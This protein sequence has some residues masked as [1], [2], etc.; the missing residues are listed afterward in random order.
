MNI[1]RCFTIAGKVAVVTGGSAGIG[2]MIAEGLVRAGA[3]VFI[4]GRKQE[5]LGE[6]VQRLSEFGE[7][8]PIQADLG[9]AEGIQAVKLALEARV[10]ELNILINNAGTIWIAPFEDFPRLGFEKLFALNVTALFDLTRTL[11]PLLQRGA[12]QDDPARVVNVT[13]VAGMHIG[14]QF[15]GELD[16]FSYGASKAAANMLTRKLAR[17]LL[18]DNIL[19]N[20]VA[21]GTFPT[22]MN[23]P[24]R[25]DSE[26]QAAALRDI[27][28]GREGRAEEIAAPV[29]FLCSRAANYITGV[30]LPVTGGMATLD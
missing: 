28:L 9:T 13:S 29:I 5:E 25:N 20:A 2:S 6:T 26:A 11:R 12:T 14:G 1:D 8:F 21:P 17:T 4:V 22:R 24:V 10:S 27:P 16:N 23:K 7:I 30:I 18:A 19:V 3:K 15:Y